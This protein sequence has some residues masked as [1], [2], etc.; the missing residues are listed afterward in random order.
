[1]VTT[2]ALP[3]RTDWLAGCTDCHRQLLMASALVLTLLAGKAE[4]DVVQGAWPSVESQ[5]VSCWFAGGKE[6]V[7]STRTV[8]HFPLIYHLTSTIS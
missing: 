3:S 6:F 7:I 5:L 1:M 8:F 4:G 2:H